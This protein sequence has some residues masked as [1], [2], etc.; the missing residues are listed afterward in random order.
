M[1]ALSARIAPIKTS[2]NSYP[3]LLVMTVLLAGG[4]TLVPISASSA[5]ETSALTLT[6]CRLEG[7]GGFRK[8]K[9]EC[10][11]LAAP[12]NPDE[13][14]GTSIDLYVARVPALT[15]T[16]AV[17]AFTYIAGGPGQ[18]STEAYVSMREA[19]ELIRRERDIILVDQR[20][21]GRSNRQ[22]CELPEDR[23]DYD[24]ESWSPEDIAAFTRECLA[25]LGDGARYYTTSIAVE[26]L[27]RLRQAFGYPQLDLYGISYGTRV[28]QHYL[29]RYPQQVRSVIL[30]GVVPVTMPLGPDIAINAQHAL[31]QVFSR[32]A[33]DVPCTTAF[34]DIKNKFTELQNRLRSDPPTVS[35]PDPISG[36]PVESVVSHEHLHIAVRLMSYSPDTVS[37]LPLMIDAAFNGNYLPVAA[38]ALLGIENLNNMLAYGM[39]NTV[40]C[41]EDTPFYEGYDV[42]RDLL[43]QSY[44]GIRSYQGLIDTCKDWPRGPVD[45]NFRQPFASNAPVLVLSGE[46]DPVTPASYGEMV[47]DY[48]GNAE[49][50]VIDGQGHGQAHVGCMPRLMAAFIA[51]LDPPGLD[52]GCLDTQ[53]AAP[54]F[55]SY[56]GPEP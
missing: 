16:P 5:P 51:D 30:D 55:T 15:R 40:V 9:A 2:K 56:S 48:L 6:P 49:H 31:D 54:F 35:H 7:F 28:A 11:T 20:G 50:I 17:S 39:H 27:E 4:A 33:E 29:R 53:H 13:P 25:A 18:A 45:T 38:Q 36:E 22:Q 14:D 41:S 10:G 46:A 43:E 34:G 26:D 19:F 3:I 47:S 42:N 21:T 32:C 24:L 12:L 44:M 8:I 1:A 37:L 52:T 23:R